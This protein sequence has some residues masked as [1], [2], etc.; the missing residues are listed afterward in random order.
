MGIQ[1]GELTASLE[2]FIDFEY[3]IAQY[4]LVQRW[5]KLCLFPDFAQK[6]RKTPVFQRWHW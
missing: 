3:C 5:L 2:A 1:A 4:S 6:I